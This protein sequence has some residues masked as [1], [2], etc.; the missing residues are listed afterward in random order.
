MVDASGEESERF[1][2]D[3]KRVHARMRALAVRVCQDSSLADDALQTAYTKAYVA[4]DSFRGE[5]DISTWLYRI[6]YRSC[7]DELRKQKPLEMLDENMPTR[8]RSFEERVDESLQLQHAL[9]EL[10]AEQ[11]AS[12]WL[13]DAEGH[14]Y[15]AAAQILDVPEGTVASRVV[16]ARKALQR[17]LRAGAENPK[18][19]IENEEGR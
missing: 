16:R 12:I 17:A 9:N 7:I 6:V 3:L 4:R 8:G 15:A 5:A 18:N 10:T 13:V 14:T 19:E 2:A 1:V 11:R